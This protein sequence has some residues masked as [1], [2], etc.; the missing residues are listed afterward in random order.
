MSTTIDNLYSR[1]DQDRVK[2]RI[3]SIRHLDDLRH[4]IE[5]QYTQG[6]F[7][8]E[9]YRERLTFYKFQPPDN[10]SSASSIIVAALPRPQ[11]R[12]GFTWKGK[13]ITL[14]LPP[15]YV[16]Y[17]I[18][19]QR[20]LKILRK[21]LEPA[22]FRVETASLPLKSLA[23]RSGL[24][25]Y[26]R[27]NICYVPGMGSFHQL[28]AFYSNVPVDEEAWTDPSMMDRCGKCKTCLR[29][30]PTNAIPS[31][32]FLLHAEKCIVFHNEK[33]ADRPFPAW[34]DP[35]S[36]NALIGCLPCQLV[37]PENRPFVDWLGP[38]KPIYQK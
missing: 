38:D 30:C 7:D 4:E 11:T 29:H 8:E 12:V 3:V 18:I 25:K 26:G 33:P 19:P 21:S 2:A 17:Q 20:T 1:L 16:G 24:G 31:N 27:N 37:C 10:F 34:I 13:T 15:T 5:N 9:F 28:S 23:V 14:I 6:H 36:H 32:R 22:G 35:K